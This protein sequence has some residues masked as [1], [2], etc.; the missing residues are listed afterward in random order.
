MHPELPFHL[1]RRHRLLPVDV[2]VTAT[3]TTNAAAKS[4]A[5]AVFVE[6]EISRLHPRLLR[7]PLRQSQSLLSRLHQ[8]RGRMVSPQLACP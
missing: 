7:L 3:T 6:A 1:L 4:A 2:A 5:F 8:P